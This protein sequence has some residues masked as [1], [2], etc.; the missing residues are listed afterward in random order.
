MSSSRIAPLLGCLLIL[1]AGAAFGQTPGY[2]EKVVQW[3]VKSGESCEAIAKALYGSAEHAALVMRYNDVTCTPGAPLKDGITLVLPAKVTSLPTATITSVNPETRAKPAGGGWSKAYAGQALARQSSVNTREKG[4]AG[5]QFQDRTRVYLAEHTL[6]ILYGTAAQTQVSKTP[7]A[8]VELERGELQA[9]LAALRGRP[10]GIDVAGGGRVDAKSRD[11]V[12]AKK[13]K[14]TNVSVFHGSAAVQSAGKKVDVPTNYGTRFWEKKAPETPRP[15]PPAPTWTRGSGP[16][17]LAFGGA[18]IL[19]ASWTAVPKAATYRVEISRDAKFTDLLAREHV[20]A[21]VLSFRAEQIPA[22]AYFM[23]VRAIDT[24]DFLGI[25]SAVRATELVEAAWERGA[26]EVSDAGLRVGRYAILALPK[27]G[28]L[29]LAADGGTFGPAP[30]KLDFRRRSP[31]SIVLRRGGAEQRFDVSYVDPTATL[32]LTRDGTLV[33]VEVTFGG[34]DGLN[35]GEVLRPEARIRVAGQT[36]VVPLRQV[37]KQVYRGSTAL[38][39]AD[40]PLDVEVHDDFGHLLATSADA[41]PAP[42]PTPPPIGGPDRIQLGALAPAIGISP[43]TSI[44]WTSPTGINHGHVGVR[45]DSDRSPVALQ[46]FAMVGGTF[47]PVSIDATVM[48]PATAD[49]RPDSSALFGARFL[50]HREDD[51]S[52]LI[53]PSLR[54]AVPLDDLGPAPRL[55]PLF[56]I[57]GL[58]GSW[59]WLVNA[60]ARLRLAGPPETRTFVDAVQA[61]TL[62]G[63][64]YDVIDWL[65]LY[66]YLDLHLLVPGAGM[67]SRFRGGLSLGVEAGDSVYVSVGG[68]ATPWDDVGAGY[69]AGQLAIGFREQREP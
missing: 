25:A 28:G 64:S 55:E 2:P 60:G 19:T 42:S 8:A 56:A 26:G 10:V 20:P 11:A 43:R 58:D 21:D 12:V 61:F 67:S 44:S 50:I 5:I 36:L 54:V 46:G 1:V 23:R 37:T 35:V 13:G 16:L 6:V 62:G 52:L 29:S 41:T 53:A 24:D 51:D 68:R 33:T 22:G 57:G 31:T 32:R 69:V 49:A 18:G 59:T 40:A 66:S 63:G 45:L 9:G 34:V 38:P 39:S 3:T 17:A 4:R 48:S 47:G 7:P 30:D 15:L 65:R 14:Q 27:P